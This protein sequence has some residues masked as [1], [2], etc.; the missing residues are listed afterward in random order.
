MK[1]ERGKCTRCGLRTV[2]RAGEAM[3][4]RPQYR[5]LNGLCIQGAPTALPWTKGHD[6]YDWDTEPS[7][8]RKIHRG[9]AS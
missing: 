6:G 4:G 7:P 5:C 8:T 1:E 3:D 9:H 2:M